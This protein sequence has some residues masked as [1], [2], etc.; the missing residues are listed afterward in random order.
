MLYL[1]Q[2]RL[3][4]A[5]LAWPK[6]TKRGPKHEEKK[7]RKWVVAQ[8]GCRAIEKSRKWDV[9]QLGCRAD[10]LSRSWNVAQL[11]CRATEISR[12]WNVAQLK[13]R[14]NKMS[15]KWMSRR[16]DVALEKSRENGISPAHEAEK[17]KKKPGLK[18]A[19]TSMSHDSHFRPFFVSLYSFSRIQGWQNNRETIRKYGIQK[20]S[21]FMT[22]VPIWEH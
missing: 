3:T 6:L 16:W 1:V 8:M 18:Q 15:L 12:N 2:P 10:G 14:A 4:Q 7:S 17:N 13:W 20:M 19:N 21:Y 5:D 22:F 11:K 9:A